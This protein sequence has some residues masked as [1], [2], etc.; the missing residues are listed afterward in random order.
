M[1]C[2]L[3]IPPQENVDDGWPLALFFRLLDIVGIN[4][5]I[6]FS[7]NNPSH[8]VTRRMFLR[9]V[10]ECLVKPG[11]RKR[12]NSQYLTKDLRAKAAK[13]SGVTE[14]NQGQTSRERAPKPG[15]C[16]ICP[17]KK[18]KKTNAYCCKCYEVMCVKHMKNVCEKCF[19][20]DE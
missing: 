3:L 5:Q 13:L 6:I 18:D 19:E 14:E 16:T 17:R 11:I 7:S 2:V 10:G 1:R 8:E 4:A 12:I 20:Q 15:R 9:E